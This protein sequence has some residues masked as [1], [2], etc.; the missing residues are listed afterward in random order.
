M[1]TAWQRLTALL[2]AIVNWRYFKPAVFVGCA[3][4]L[5]D[6]SYSLWVILSGR[7]P[8]YL[9]AD[10]GKELLHLSGED[11]LAI[12]LITLSRHAHSAA[13]SASTASRSSGGCS[14]CGRSPMRS[15]TCR[16]I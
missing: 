6:L 16:C 10:P 9:G 14:A 12:L 7:N 8:D 2:S 5:V 1:R 11:A 13:S 15:F 4:P 3:I